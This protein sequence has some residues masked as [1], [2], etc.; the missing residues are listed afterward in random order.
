ML[1]LAE[2]TPAAFGVGALIITGAPSIKTTFFYAQFE[3]STYTAQ[4]YNEL[5]DKSELINTFANSQKISDKR[6]LQFQHG[7]DY[8]VAWYDADQQRYFIYKF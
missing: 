5:V 1:I 6:I 3:S 8:W 2:A 7:A 4:P